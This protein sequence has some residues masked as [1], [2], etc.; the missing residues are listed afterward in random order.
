GFPVAVPGAGRTEV[1]RRGWTT[2]HTLR[3]AY[4]RLHATRRVRLQSEFENRDPGRG[5]RV[6][7]FA[8]GEAAGRDPDGFQ[9]GD[10]HRA[11]QRWRHYLRRHA[12]QSLSRRDTA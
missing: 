8:R 5:R 7:W 9:P 12:G 11:Q 6:L 2:A 3:T 1:C 10:E 4:H